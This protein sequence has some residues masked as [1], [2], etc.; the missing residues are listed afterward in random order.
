MK[1]I[2]MLQGMGNNERGWARLMSGFGRVV[3]IQ[4]GLI[5]HV[6]V[7]ADRQCV[8]D[9]PKVSVRSTRGLDEMTLSSLTILRSLARCREHT[10]GQKLDVII[11][12]NYSM[13]LAA[14]WL[15]A[16][17]RTRKVVMVLTDHLPLHGS[18][19]VRVHR[20]LCAGLTRWAAR[21]A[22][23]VWTVSPRIPTASVNP[24]HYLV[25]ICLDDNGV[26]AGRREEVGYVGFPSPDHALDVLFEICRKH[27][28]PLNIIGDSPYL[29]AIRSQA[30]PGTRFHG[31][32]ND[33]AKINAVLARCFCGYA[34][35]RSAGPENYSYYGI[36]SKTFYYFASNVPVVTTNTA[37]FTPTIETHR[38]GRVVDPV[39]EQIEAA[40]LQL[41][42]EFPAFY[43]A[44]GR[45]R[46]EWNVQVESFHRERLAALWADGERR[47]AC[48]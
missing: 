17:G 23:E 16:S 1:Q 19:A 24:R 21:R 47:K 42:N 36:P 31:V 6:E 30:P 11:A 39:P 15:R 7:W 29:Q 38:V 8:F 32:L 12:S 3:L 10:R 46:R 41:K 2:V 33:Q 26:P 18:L 5:Q 13:G 14:L 27:A 44:I 43:A 35:Y 48:V 4:Q 28:F 25:P 40:I 34:V 9:G 20:R 22:D 37:H 45:F